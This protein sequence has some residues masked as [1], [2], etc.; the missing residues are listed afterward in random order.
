MSETAPEYTAMELAVIRRAIAPPPPAPPG[1]IL[2]AMGSPPPPWMRPF[3]KLVDLEPD[4]FRRLAG[5]PWV[6]ALSQYAFFPEVVDW[7]RQGRSVPGLR[8]TG[9]TRG[10]VAVLRSGDAHLA[11]KPFQYSRE[12]EI[13]RIAASR[14]VGPEQF[15]SLPGYLTEQFVEGTFFTDLPLERRDPGTMRAVGLQLGGM[16]RRLHEAGVYY[17]DAT[18]S[19]PEGRSH[20]IVDGDG[21]CTLID[22]GVSLLLD[23]HPD[24]TREEVHNF[25]RTLPMYRIFAGMADSAAEMD[26]FLRSYT[27]SMAK[28]SPGEILSR[29]LHFAQQGLSSAARRMGRHIIAPLREGFLEAYRPAF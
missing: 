1:E 21:H 6:H 20:L 18:L 16:L 11:I 8:T 25:V 28:S 10:P 9:R 2:K 5:D 3:W 7:R 19:D 27:Q 17:N 22:F 13:A 26:D 29:D 12:D 23:R 15:P 14:N 24:Y 4:L